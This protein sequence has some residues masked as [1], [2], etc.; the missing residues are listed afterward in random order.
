M[1]GN[2]PAKLKLFVCDPIKITVN[3]DDCDIQIGNTFMASETYVSDADNKKTCETGAAW[4]EN[5]ANRYNPTTQQYDKG[6]YT[7]E[8]IDNAPIKNVVITSLEHRGQGV[9]LIK[10]L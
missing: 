4:A 3:Y 1:V 2:I 7:V 9:E 10:L 8:E 6:S 5:T